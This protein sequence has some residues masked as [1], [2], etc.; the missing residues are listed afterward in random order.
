MMQ[1][2]ERRSCPKCGKI[3]VKKNVDHIM[4]GNITVKMSCEDKH[5]WIEHYAMTYTGYEY[6]SCR[7][8]SFGNLMWD[9]NKLD[10]EEQNR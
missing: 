5:E 9:K 6:D 3:Y 1:K 8:D 2:I 4:L 7:Y 10:G